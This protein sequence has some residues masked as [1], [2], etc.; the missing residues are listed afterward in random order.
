MGSPDT[1]TIPHHPP[2]LQLVHFSSTQHQTA[3]STVSKKSEIF[4]SINM[5]FQDKAQAHITQ[6]DKELSKYPVLNN[7]EKQ[8]SVP[9]V[10]AFLGLI[11]TYFFFIFFNIG[12]Q[13]LTNVAGFIIPCKRLSSTAS[14][15]G[16]LS[17]ATQILRSASIRDT[18]GHG[19]GGKQE[20]GLEETVNLGEG[21]G[22]MTRRCCGIM[23]E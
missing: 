3:P 5:S 13:L 2:K 22:F 1:Y 11:A 14:Q 20:T 15:Y 17:H 18:N 4:Q 21:S 16:L 6:I 9:K 8:T 19:K 12:G 23:N 7:L 10:Y